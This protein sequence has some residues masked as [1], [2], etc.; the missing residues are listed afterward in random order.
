MGSSTRPKGEGLPCPPSSAKVAPAQ[1]L[2]GPTS[3]LSRSRGAD[4]QAP[5]LPVCSEAQ[6]GEEER[7]EVSG[8]QQEPEE[9]LR[10]RRALGRIHSEEEE[11]VQ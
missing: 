4:L 7:Q 9:E 5:P 2:W 6:P 1:G 10:G 11:G 8:A 3:H